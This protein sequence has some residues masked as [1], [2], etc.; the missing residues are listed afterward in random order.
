LSQDGWSMTKVT[1]ETD[2]ASRHVPLPLQP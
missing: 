1:A 2:T